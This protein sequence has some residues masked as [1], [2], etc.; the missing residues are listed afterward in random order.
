MKHVCLFVPNFGSLW[1]IAVHFGSLS[2]NM[3]HCH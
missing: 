3:S 2:P 1:L